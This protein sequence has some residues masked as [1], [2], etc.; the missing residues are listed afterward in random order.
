MK[1]QRC[2]FESS[3]EM[4]FCG[5]CGCELIASSDLP[6]K[7]QS[8][9]EKLATVQRDLIQRDFPDAL[10]EDMAKNILAQKGKIER[11]PREVTILSCGMK[12]FTSPAEKRC[13]NG[14]VCLMTFLVLSR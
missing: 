1:C 5:K 3:A 7:H 9:E 12:G 8:F 14:S 4:H 11:N 13:W 10:A 2:G 6:G